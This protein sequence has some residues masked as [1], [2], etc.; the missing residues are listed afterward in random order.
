MAK[1]DNKTEN[2]TYKI[3]FESA[4]PDRE[5]IIKGKEIKVL[6]D[7]KKIVE[8]IV[9]KLTMKDG[10]TKTIDQKTYDYMIKG[11]LLLTPEQKEEKD[12]IRR[13]YGAMKRERFTA[14][15]APPSI[16]D[17]EKKQIYVDLPY[18]EE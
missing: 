6:P 9:P 16:T 11:G 14:T 18:L 15:S 10:Q 8:Q 13:K 5:F 4:L 12:A 3:K 2:K 17:E 7:G 1:N